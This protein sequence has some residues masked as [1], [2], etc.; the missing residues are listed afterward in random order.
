MP[1][2]GTLGSLVQAPIPVRVAHSRAKVRSLGLLWLGTML[3]FVV[4]A[5]QSPEK[6]YVWLLC[7][8][9]ITLCV[10]VAIRTTAKDAHCAVCSAQL[11]EIIEA[12]RA[13]KT[14]ITFCPQCGTRIETDEAATED[15]SISD[16]SP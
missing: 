10:L 4:V 11:Y 5:L 13:I 6:R 1:L 2:N 16:A 7:M 9:V 14:K 12:A 15:K 8:T 3:L